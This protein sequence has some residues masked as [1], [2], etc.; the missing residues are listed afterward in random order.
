MGS[1]SLLNYFSVFRVYLSGFFILI[2]S[3][4][5]L[6][7]EKV[8]KFTY[9]GTPENL[10][11]DTL[12]LPIDSH[13]VAMSEYVYV[14]TP[15]DSLLNRQ[16]NSIFFIIDNSGSMKNSYG[17]DRWGSRY[18]VT[19]DLIDTIYN[20]NPRMQV[21]LVIF[22]SHLFFDPDNDPVFAKCP[23]YDTGSFIPLY[24][25]MFSIMANRVII[26]LRI[27]LKLIRLARTHING[28]IQFMIR[29]ISSCHLVVLI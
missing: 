28:Q 24:S 10:N 8:C 5:F 25:W 15:I 6:P 7:A 20:I 13:V 18:T 16:K 19:H 9:I 22:G 27:T 12:V 17:N 4:T 3:A 21:G 29:Q 1:H 23:V 2:F 26:Y 14:G 11:A